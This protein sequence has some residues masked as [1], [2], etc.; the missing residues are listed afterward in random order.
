MLKSETRI[1]FNKHIKNFRI[2]SGFPIDQEIIHNI[3]PL[4]KLGGGGGGLY[5]YRTYFKS[6]LLGIKD[7]FAVT[8]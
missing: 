6:V 8:V 4:V 3:G 2:C 7:F 5:W 1:H